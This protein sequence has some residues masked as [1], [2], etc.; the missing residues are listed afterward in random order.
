MLNLQKDGGPRRQPEVIG[1]Q[2]AGERGL[3]HESSTIHKSKKILRY[4]KS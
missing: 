3:D 2:G 4:H 1:G